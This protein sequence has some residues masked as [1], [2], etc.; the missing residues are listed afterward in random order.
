M[1]GGIEITP[2]DELTRLPLSVL[3]RRT[4]FLLSDADYHHHFHPL[5]ST[6]LGYDDDGKKLPT[7]N[8]DY[9]PG[10][11][12]RFSRG[13]YLPKW[14]HSNYHEIFVGP[15]L[16]QT[17]EEKFTTVVLACA[18]VVPRQAIN[19]YTPGEY[20]V[21]NLSN[22]Q[23]DFIRRRIYFEGAASAVNRSRK[24]RLGRFIA[25][26]AISNALGEIIDEA[27]I[28]K[29]AGDF[30]KPTSEQ[31]RLEAGHY[32]LMQAVGASVANLIDIHKEAQKEGMIGN[33]KR[34]LGE[35]VL[36][37]FPEYKFPDYYASLEDRLTSLDP[38]IA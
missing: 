8:P 17:A 26:Y 19:L 18:G 27:A 33:T 35:V 34:K 4:D 38:S 1:P 5:K 31:K 30:L 7:D 12:V 25:E 14:L 11:A 32:L 22:R 23:H 2:R 3:T 15:E 37:Y 13:Q 28:R 10:R 21:V 36:K 16:P 29:K 6:E 20:E 24:N 9:L